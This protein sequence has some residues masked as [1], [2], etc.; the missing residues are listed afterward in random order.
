LTVDGFDWP[1][2][3]AAKI[4]QDVCWLTAPGM[5]NCVGVA[6]RTDLLGMML[7]TVPL[8]IKD[9]PIDQAIGNWA[10]NFARVDVA[11]TRP[12]I[13]DHRDGP[14]T[15]PNDLRVD[16]RTD[17]GMRKAWLFGTRV[18]WDKSVLPL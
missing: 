5:A 9:R 14:T 7:C 15:I 2:R 6:I 4:A 12:S 16:G 3:I 10:H 18:S 1:N 11:Y 13:V 17:N 8:L